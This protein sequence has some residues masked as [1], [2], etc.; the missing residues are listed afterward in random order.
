MNED[1]RRTLRRTAKPTAS[2]DSF[3]KLPEERHNR[4]DEVLASEKL[5]SLVSQLNAE[6]DQGALVVV[7]GTR[8][9]KALQR[10]GLKG[11]AFKLCYTRNSLSAV[12]A[13]AESHRKVV[14]LLDYDL[15]G[16]NLTRKV[17]S[18]LQKKGIRVDTSYRREIRAMTNGLAHHVEDL[19]RFTS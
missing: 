19:K 2:G 14:L 6:L 5:A 15:K 7:E 11:R 9:E 3:A 17:A 10:L 4:L 16:R 12:L 13:E 8:D 1:V 18:M